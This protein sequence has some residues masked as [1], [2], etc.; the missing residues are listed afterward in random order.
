M[1]QRRVSFAVSYL[2]M[3]DFL[4]LWKNDLDAGV[5]TKF[6]GRSSSAR[7][8]NEATGTVRISKQ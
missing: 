5:F 7:M 2:Y 1:R 6:P 3:L 4:L 8:N